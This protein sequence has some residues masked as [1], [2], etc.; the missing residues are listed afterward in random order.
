MT[1][2]NIFK[3]FPDPVF[4]YKVNNYKDYNKDLLTYVYNIY[5]EDK[6]GIQLS[7]VN[8]WHSKPFNLREKNSPP[9]NFF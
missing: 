5:N 7:N 1:K 8:G 4:R 6:D 3:F 9:N 2:D